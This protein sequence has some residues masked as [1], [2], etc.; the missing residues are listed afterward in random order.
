VKAIGL[1]ARDSLRLEAGLCLYGHDLDETTS[2]IEAGLAWT[3]QKVRRERADF[4]GAQRILKEL[5]EKP[6]R[7][8]VGLLPMDKAPARE[9]AEIRDLS[10]KKVGIV[11]SGGFGPTVGGPVAMGYV[12]AASAQVGTQLDVIVRDQA[13]R[14][15]VASLPFVPHNYHRKG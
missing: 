9:G 11:T 2:P 7:K 3:I 12:D 10:G 1:G 8:R 6:S 15:T 14:W 5:A 13:R 4:P